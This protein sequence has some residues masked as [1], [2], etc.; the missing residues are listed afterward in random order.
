MQPIAYLFFKDTCREAMTRYGEIFGTEP[1]IMA[2]GD[3]P[4]EDRAQMPGVAADAVMHASLPVGEGWLFASDDPIGPAPVMSGCNVAVALPDEAETR[5]VWEAL[6]EGA[7][8]RQDL[9]PMFWTP[10]FGTLTDRFGI[11]WMIMTDSPTP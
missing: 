6:A 7:E 4:E 10:L 8:V 11:R 5:R 3:M 9:E 2:F 1:E